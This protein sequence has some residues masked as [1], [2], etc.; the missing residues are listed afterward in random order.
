VRENR[1]PLYLFTGLLIG[2]IFGL[3]YAW[4][5]EP[6]QY[7]DGLPSQL[8]PEG[9]D[10]WRAMIAL[11]Y[12]ADSNLGRARQRLALLNDSSPAQALAAQAQQVTSFNT[13]EARALSLLAEA[14]NPRPTPIVEQSPTVN[15]SAGPTRGPTGVLSPTAT[16]DPAQ[17]VRTATPLPPTAIF[18]LTATPAASLTPRPTA[19]AT[20][21]LGAPFALKDKQKVC[22]PNLPAMLQVEVLNSANQPVPGVPVRVSWPPA[23]L[24]TFFTGLN[25]ESGLGYADFLMTPK[26]L[27]AV[28][29][30]EN[31]ESV[32][33]IST[34]DCAQPDG[35]GTFQGGWKIKF[36]QP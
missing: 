23:N 11:A 15:P 16:L 35:S 24:D 13:R 20:P 19:R 17:V 9:R 22:D 3:L 36:V 21:T 25:P 5:V 4:L 6:V 1:G 29:A 30:G 34:Q 12:Q 18:T 26:I 10:R 31:G 7:Y 2:L 27:Y 32:T 28:Q 33:G 14:Y 8:G